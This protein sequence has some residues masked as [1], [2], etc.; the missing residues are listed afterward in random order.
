MSQPDGKRP[1]LEAS[2]PLVKGTSDWLPI[3]HARLSGLEALVLERFARA[4]YERINT[5][6]LELVDLHER[7][8]GAGIVSKLF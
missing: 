3:D 4:G 1:V 6:V 5:P 8:S 2:I 7:K